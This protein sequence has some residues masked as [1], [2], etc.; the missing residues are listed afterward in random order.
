[1][2]NLNAIK[3]TDSSAVK[4]QK[5]GRKVLFAIIRFLFLISIGYIVLFPLFDMIS[6]SVK[7]VAGYYD[8]TV[9]W[10]PREFTFSW[11]ERALKFFDI[12]NTLFS[13]LSIQILS[14]LIEV[15]TCAFVA[16]GFARFKFPL[17]RLCEV[18][19]LATILVPVQVYILP[20]VLNFRYFDIFGILGLLENLT[21]ETLRIN[22]LNTGWT[23]W[24][25]SVLAV[26]LRA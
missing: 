10:I 16:Y 12:G 13:T 8:A 18:I 3:L 19:L 5:Q 25:P 1:M 22:L 21:G 23:F 2:K 20:V 4:M 24:L 26:G 7:T 6:N 9:Y 15:F 17:K 11:Y 14:G